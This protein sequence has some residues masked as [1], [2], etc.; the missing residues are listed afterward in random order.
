MLLCI[1]NTFNREI[2]RHAAQVFAKSNQ[3]HVYRIIV[4]KFFHIRQTQMLKIASQ[5]S[6]FA[7]LFHFI[8][9]L[10]PAACK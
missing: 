10:L 7:S 4:C 2:R 1:L 3:I 5:S 6:N 8:V 9:E